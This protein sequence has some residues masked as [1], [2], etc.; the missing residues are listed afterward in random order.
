MVSLIGLCVPPTYSIPRFSP[1]CLA[2][3]LS[4]LCCL[5]N[6]SLSRSLAASCVSLACDFRC[7]LRSLPEVHP[8]QQLRLLRVWEVTRLLER[9]R[10]LA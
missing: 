4:A 10:S 2:I 5:A 8:E 9:I 7:V 3:P 6:S 1:S